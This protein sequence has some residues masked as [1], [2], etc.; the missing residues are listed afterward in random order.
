MTITACSLHPVTGAKVSGLDLRQPI[1][2]A[3]AAEL[4]ALCDRHALRVEH[5]PAA[6]ARVQDLTSTR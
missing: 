1:G 2:G 4:R 6:F 3:D 5:R